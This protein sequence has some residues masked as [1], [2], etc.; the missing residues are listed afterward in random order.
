MITVYTQP[1]CVQCGS[2]K[3]HLAKRK[4]QFAEQPMDLIRARAVEA[5]ITSAPVV[6]VDDDQIW[7][8]Y[9]PDRIDALVGLTRLS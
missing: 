6:V 8:G 3:R 5:G 1:D 7:G 9:R 4:L 2:T